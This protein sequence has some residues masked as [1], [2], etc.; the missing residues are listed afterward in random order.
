MRPQAIY[1]TRIE[2]NL[3]ELILLAYHLQDGGI[4][5]T[6]RLIHDPVASVLD[7]AEIRIRLERAQRGLPELHVL[8]DKHVMLAPEPGKSGADI[9]QRFQ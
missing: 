2:T 4:D 7:D 6:W 9:W 8:A 1:R 5:R 3:L